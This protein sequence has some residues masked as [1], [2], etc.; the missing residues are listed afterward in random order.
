VGTNAVCD[1]LNL[2]WYI[3]LFGEVDKLLSA[4][5]DAKV[6]LRVTTVDGDCTHAHGSYKRSAL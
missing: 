2:G 5:L 1:L 3:L 6:A 4:H